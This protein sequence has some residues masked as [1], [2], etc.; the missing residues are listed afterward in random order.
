MPYYLY[1]SSLNSKIKYPLEIIY[2]LEFSREADDFIAERVTP[3]EIQLALKT[4]KERKVNYSD[5]K[6][7]SLYAFYKAL[8]AKED[9][10]LLRF[11]MF[12]LLIQ[13]FCY[14]GN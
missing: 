2:Q 1:V 3:S 13:Y 14:F 10:L 4:A 9:D 6:Y 7:S 8:K 12:E 5:Y 11:D